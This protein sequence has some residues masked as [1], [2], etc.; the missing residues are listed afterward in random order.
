MFN[1]GLLFTLELVPLHNV[2]LAQFDGLFICIPN[3][4]T[5]ELG[6]NFVYDSFVFKIVFSNVN[7]L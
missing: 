2:K 5:L 4:F 6:C 3:T 7:A 1:N